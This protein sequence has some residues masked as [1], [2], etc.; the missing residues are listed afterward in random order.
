M[1][2]ANYDRTMRNVKPVFDAG[3][4]LRRRA[5]PV[6][7][8]PDPAVEAAKR[9]RENLER[10]A[11]F[12]LNVMRTKA[13]ADVAA[14]RAASE[15]ARPSALGRQHVISFDAIAKRISSATGVNRVDLIS[16]RRTKHICFARHALMYWASRLTTLS[17]PEIGRRI[18]DRDHTTI[19][20]GNH[21]YVGKRA[22]MHR[23]LRPLDRRYE[24]GK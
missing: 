20:H 2:V 1:F 21:A 5:A 18:G 3:I 15:R 16:Q 12:D 6:A 7:P 19:I 23:H 9:I 10:N 13:N 8:E 17:L 14:A 11:A 24:A 22:A 4:D